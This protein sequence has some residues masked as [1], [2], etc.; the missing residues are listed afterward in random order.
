MPVTLW[1]RFIRLTFMSHILYIYDSASVAAKPRH[2]EELF[3]FWVF[4][5]RTHN[6]RVLSE[7]GS[8]QKDPLFIFRNSDAI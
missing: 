6:C 2:V 7:R 3:N 4:T 1:T 5:L 8:Q